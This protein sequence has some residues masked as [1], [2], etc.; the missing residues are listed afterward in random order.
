MLIKQHKSVVRQQKQ[1]DEFIVLVNFNGFS[2][3][4][5]LGTLKE[6]DDFSTICHIIHGEGSLFIKSFTCC[7]LLFSSSSH[8]SLPNLNLVIAYYQVY[9]GARMHFSSDWNL[10][11]E[12]GC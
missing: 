7:Y 11:H 2:E 6:K 3:L 8:L 12:F 9:I 5:R 4:E 1:E 10:S